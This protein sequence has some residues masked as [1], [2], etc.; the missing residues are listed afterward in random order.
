MSQIKVIQ[1]NVRKWSTNKHSLCQ[2]YQTEN[3]EIILINSH[4]AR[5]NETIKIYN[6]NIH[7][8]NTINEI[9]NGVAMGIRRDIKYKLIDSFESDMFG[10]TIETT[11]GP[12]HIVTTYIPPRC[13]YLHYPDFYKI[14]KSTEPVQ[15]IL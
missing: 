2:A 12:I 8:V 10:I 7:Q 15:Y 13:P 3:A 1:H 14:L 4:G 9:H 6:Y 5:N 11:L